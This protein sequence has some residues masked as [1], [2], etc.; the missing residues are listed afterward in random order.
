MCIWK[1]LQDKQKIHVVPTPFEYRTAVI[2]QVLIPTLKAF[3]TSG[4]INLWIWIGESVLQTMQCHICLQWIDAC[5]FDATYVDQNF[6]LCLQF[7]TDPQ[8]ILT[9]NDPAW[10]QYKDSRWKIDFNL[11]LCGG[12]WWGSSKKFNGDHLCYCLSNLDFMVE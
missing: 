1:D 4:E 2:F 11:S 6:W 8:V 12:T 9:N 10:K 5:F 7:L 3:Q